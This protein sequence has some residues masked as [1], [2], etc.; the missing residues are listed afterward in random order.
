MFWTLSG[1]QD[2]RGIHQGDLTIQP[3]LA[4]GHLQGRGL[5]VL[6]W[7]ALDDVADVGVAIAVDAHALEHAIQQLA[8]AA[9]KGLSLLI[10]LSTRTLADD[11]QARLG[12]SAADHDLAAAGAQLAEATGIAAL[13]QGRQVLL[14]GGGRHRPAITR[15]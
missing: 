7:P 2:D 10:L 6:R 12:I 11:H 3:G 13:R 4:R 9:H 8:G 1:Q 5:A 15:E 14:K